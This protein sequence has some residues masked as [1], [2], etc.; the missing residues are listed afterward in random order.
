V[1]RTGWPM[2][3]LFMVSLFRLAVRGDHGGGVRPSRGGGRPLMWI[4]AAHRIF[5]KK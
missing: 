4:K 5:R 3:N 1:R 2:P